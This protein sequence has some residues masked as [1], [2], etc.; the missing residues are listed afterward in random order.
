M[1]DLFAHAGFE[2]GAPRPLADRLRP[3]ALSEVAGQD[4]LLGPD[5]ALTRLVRAGSLGSMANIYQSMVINFPLNSGKQWSTMPLARDLILYII[6]LLC[7]EWIQ[8]GKEHGL[9]WERLRVPKLVRFAVYLVIA[10]LVIWKS[11]M[12]NNFIYFQF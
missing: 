10:Q 5:G 2:K 7:V 3:Q 8:R 1:S 4:H 6:V 9:V 12:G 11:G